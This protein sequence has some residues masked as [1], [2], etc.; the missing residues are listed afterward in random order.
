[1][2]TSKILLPFKAWSDEKFCKGH[3]PEE[4]AFT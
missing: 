1:V 3:E 2:E 4:A